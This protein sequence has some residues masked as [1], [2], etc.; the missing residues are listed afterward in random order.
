MTIAG[1]IRGALAAKLLLF[2]AAVSIVL[3]LL[4]SGIEIWQDS[5]ASIS[6]EQ[7][8]SRSAVVADLDTLAL[9]VWTLDDRVLNLTAA[10]LLRGTSIIH[11]E[12][13]ED[14][15][16]RLK[17]DRPG[18]L[19]P[20][21]YSWEMPILRPNSDQ[22]IGTLKLSESYANMRAELRERAAILIVDEAMKIFA[23]SILV[24]FVAYF[25]ITRP[26]RQLVR[27]V[28][29]G[30]EQ[31]SNSPIAIARPLRWGHDEIDA[32]VD[33]INANTLMRRRMEAEQLRHQSREANAG[34]LE[35]LGQLAGGV[36]HDF[37]N[38]LGAILGF[39]GLLK[40]DVADKPEQRRFVQRIIT[41]CE[42]GREL[43]G[44]IRAF[45]RE[46]GTERKTV[47]LVRIARQ[48][49]NLLS[50]SLPKTTRLRFDNPSSELPVFGNEALLGQIVTNLCMN[51][52][53]ALDG[54]PGDVQM[55]VARALP[56]ELDALRAG[57]AAAG[58]RL[59]GE[60]GASNEY[61]CM[62][63][64]DTAGGISDAVLDRIF[65]PF[66]TTKGRQRGTGLG[67][68]VVHG[69][70]ESHGGACHVVSRAGVGTTFSV[71]LPLCPSPVAEMARPRA[72][73]TVRGRER[74]LVV[75]DEPDLI[76]MLTIG[77]ERLGYDAV[78]VTDPRDALAAFKEDSKAWDTVI[79]DE[80]MPTMRG[81]ELIRQMR[82]IRSDMKFVLCTGYSDSAT[83]EI[84]RK[85]GVDIFLLKPVDATIIAAKLRQMMDAPVK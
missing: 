3:A 37:N 78:G 69:A 66:F 43:I 1:R 74:I 22:R 20:A 24:F 36:A 67:L 64:S 52:S 76:D 41:A 4:I 25:L 19:P 81:L 82:A 50:A 53:E 59:V 75:D 45:A 39:A 72:S 68:A 83:D 12:V 46:E 26:L 73:H 14:G 21:E 80:V 61:A 55:R 40:E 48:I 38:M 6:N 23:T 11:V 79:T 57:T 32:L 35:A 58:E 31:D 27:Q 71:Y 54:H 13:V 16:T 9:A 10:S 51:A 29:D 8:E 44:Q 60:I 34:K 17:L 33:A 28:Q 15:E 84:M 62:Q 5:R 2:T 42:R 70:I 30:A 7:S 56:S 65:E 49:T 47:D 63:V 77:F 85:A 18:V